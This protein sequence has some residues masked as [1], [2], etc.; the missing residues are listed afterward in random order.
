LP[1]SG[2]K[3]DVEVDV[4][5]FAVRK[6]LVWIATGLSAIALLLVVA[7][8][9]L[10]LDN[11]SRQA[12]VGQRQQVINQAVSLSQLNEV[13]VRALAKQAIDNKD[14]KLL[15][16]LAENGIGVTPGPAAAAPTPAPAPSS[17]AP[18]LPATKK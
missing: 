2:G 4:T 12:E 10:F 16:L 7:N 11:Q 18:L 6:W 15:N 5:P 13:L 17:S 9:A 8:A 1:D 14:D 3:V